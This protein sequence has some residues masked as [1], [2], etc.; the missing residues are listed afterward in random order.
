MNS[1]Y[2]PELETNHPYLSPF[3]EEASSIFKGTRIELVKNGK[4][5]AVIHPGAV[6]ILPLLTDNEVVLIRNERFVV[7]EILWE[8]P[9]GTLE[10][11]EHPQETAARE[12]IEETGYKASHIE[13]INMFYT[14]P[15]FCNERMYVYV[16]KNLEFV[17][18]DL[19]E[20]ERIT[21][22]I[23][24]VDEVKKMIREGSIRDGKTIAAFLYWISFS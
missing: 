11:N 22:E 15:G 12:L 14:T 13:Y 24:T 6:T 23:K 10:K 2:Q 18:Q 8:L 4:K 19:D 1:K 7:G 5:E 16:A 17:G 20:T 21:T 9:A 3:L